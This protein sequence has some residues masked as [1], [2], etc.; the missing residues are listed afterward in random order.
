MII[1]I[2]LFKNESRFLTNFLK[3]F[4]QLVKHL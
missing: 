2:Y 1:D 4:I 3:G